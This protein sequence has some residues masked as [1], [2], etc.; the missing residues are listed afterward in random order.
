MSYTPRS[1]FLKIMI[2]RGFVADCTDYER[3]DSALVEGNIAAYIGFDAL[4][5][6]ACGSLSNHDATMVTK[7]RRATYNPY[8]RRHN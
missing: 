2:E 4:L 8:G 7:N 3:L 5:N 6:H 1:D